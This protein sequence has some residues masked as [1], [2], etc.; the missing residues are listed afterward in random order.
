MGVKQLATENPSNQSFQKVYA[1]FKKIRP[2]ESAWNL[3]SALIPTV[4]VAKSVYFDIFGWP[5]SVA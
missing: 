3:L 2:Y 1:F 5:S 4:W